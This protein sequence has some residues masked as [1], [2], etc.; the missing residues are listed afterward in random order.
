MAQMIICW[1]TEALKMSGQTANFGSKG[2]ER[3]DELESVIGNQPL[4]CMEFWDGWFDHWGQGE[5]KVVGLEDHRK[6]WRI[7]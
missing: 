5:H 7:C 6:S 3:F 1:L 2:S 4:M